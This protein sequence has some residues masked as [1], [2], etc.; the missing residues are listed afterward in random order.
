MMGDPEADKSPGWL[1]RLGLRML[2]GSPSPGDSGADAAMDISVLGDGFGAAVGGVAFI[3]GL[4]RRVRRRDVAQQS[5][6][7]SAEDLPS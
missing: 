4:W 7:S 3:A 5:S 1:R 6:E 2:G